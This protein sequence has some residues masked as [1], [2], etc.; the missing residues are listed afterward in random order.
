[1]ED[2]SLPPKQ[3]NCDLVSIYMRATLIDPFWEKKHWRL[4]LKTVNETKLH[5]LY[6]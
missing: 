6:T 3:Y 4:E 5:N 1:M 2:R